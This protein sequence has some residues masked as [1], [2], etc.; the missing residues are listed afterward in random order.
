[1]NRRAKPEALVISRVTPST[2]IILAPAHDDRLA[3]AFAQIVSNLDSPESQRAYRR[4]WETFVAHLAAKGRS[5]LAATTLDVQTYLLELRAS[6]KRQNTRARALAVVRAVYAAL[7]Q[8]GVLQGANPAREAKNPKGDT[9]PMKTPWIEAADLEKF[10]DAA[11]DPD[12]FVE[13]RDYLI[14]T[15][16][17]MTGLRRAEVARIAVDDF[18]KL[19]PTESSILRVRAKGGKY[20][21]VEVVAPLARLLALW[22]R[23]LGITTG[24]LFRRSAKGGSAVGV[25]T[26]RNA[27]KRQAARAGFVDHARFTPHAFRRSVATIAKQRGVPKDE[28]QRGL[29]HSKMETTE[30]YMQLSDAPVAP[31][32]AFLD[33]LPKKFRKNV[34]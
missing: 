23:E 21:R 6:G 10:L 27:V 12:S 31:A 34:R 14:S 32:N 5:P 18:E 28:I 24:A 8:S 30:R 16:L 7:A 9:A 19:S 29:L 17:A 25:S 20:G 33:I 15:T 13:R 22:A 11:P 4:E 1:M 3:A 2:A 26:V